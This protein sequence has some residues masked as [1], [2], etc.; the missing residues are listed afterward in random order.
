MFFFGDDGLWVFELPFVWQHFQQLTLRGLGLVWHVGDDAVEVHAG[1][2]IMSLACCQQ[3]ADDGHILCCLVIAAEQIILSSQ[4]DRPDLILREV[5]VQKNSSV[6]QVMHHVAPSCV[7]IGDCLSNLRALAVLDA[8][9]LHPSLHGLHDGP[10]QL[11]AL[12]LSLVKRARLFHIENLRLVRLEGREANFFRKLSDHDLV[13]ID[14]FGRGR[15][16]GQ[17]SMTSSK[18]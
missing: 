3:R 17:T 15:L 2:H 8:L 13:I 10:G 7:G 1:I 12:L 14:D 18:P 5:V 11:L 6:L 9:G 16:E 4:S